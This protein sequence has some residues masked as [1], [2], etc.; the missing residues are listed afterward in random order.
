MGRKSP[1]S[2]DEYQAIYN[3]VANY[4]VKLSVQLLKEE[5][6]ETASEALAAYTLYRCPVIYLLIH[7]H[8]SKLEDFSSAEQQAYIMLYLTNVKYLTQE[9][10]KAFASEKIFLNDYN[11]ELASALEDMCN[12][13]L[14]IENNF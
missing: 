10:R 4:G 12:E 3:K 13:I 2:K 11:G 8:Y 1:W 7:Y 6:P 14:Y 5:G 9:F